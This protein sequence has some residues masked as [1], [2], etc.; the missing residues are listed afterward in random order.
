M[1]GITL[2][3]LLL[4]SVF[5][6]L[7]QARGGVPTLSLVFTG[8]IMGHDTQ[9]RAALND[10]TG[11]YNYDTCFSF[12]RP[13]LQQADFTIGNLEVTLAGEP[14]SGYPQFSSPDALAL[15]LKKAGFDALM[16]ANNHVLDRGQQGLERTIEILNL[17]EIQHAG[18]Y[19]NE[20]ERDTTYPLLLEKHGIRVVLLNYTYGTNGLEVPSPSIVNRIDRSIIEKDLAKAQT[21]QPD[22]IIACMHWGTEYEPLPNAEQKNLAEFLFAG[23]VDII[24]GSHP[25]VIQP[26]ERFYNTDGSKERV[27]VWSTGNFI[28][29]QKIPGTDGGAMIRIRLEKY[30]DVCRITETGYLLSWVYS[31]LVKYRSQFYLLPVISFEK[32]PK[33]FDDPVL[34][35]RMKEFGK[36][37]RY[38]LGKFNRDFPEIIFPEI[39]AR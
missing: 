34:F 13:F 36:S 17:L 1:H 21:M 26:M 18:T 33:F 4:C 14:Y 27:V 5:Q 28:S 39:N 23:G 8:D 11:Q 35:E 16:Q 15:A 31:P 22:K 20:A 12:I 3:F 37:A 32:N 10:A 38:H 24:I 2:L 25:H 29:N 9:I 6:A 30:D 7:S 19:R